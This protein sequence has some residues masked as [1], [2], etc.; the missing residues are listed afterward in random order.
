M[1]NK[2]TF[3]RTIAEITD[4]P[5]SDT[6]DAFKH[7]FQTVAKFILADDKPNLNKQGIEVEDFD[8]VA[9]S[10]VYM[11]V[12]MNFSKRG[13]LKNHIG[14]IP[15]GLITSTDKVISED[16]TN[17]LM[18]NAVLWTD[19]YPEEIA[20]LKESHASGDPEKLP[21]ISYEMAYADSVSKNGTQWL[22]KL[23]TLAA[24]FVKTPA[25]GSRTALLALASA[26]EMTLTDLAK[27]LMVLAKVEDQTFEKGG[28]IVDEKEMKALQ[29]RLAQVE[30]DLELARTE[31]STKAETIVSLQAQLN[32]KDEKITVLSSEKDALVKTQLIDARV[33][34]LA[35]HGIVLEADAEKAAKKKEFW[36]SLSDADFDEYVSDLQAA[37]KSSNKISLASVNPTISAQPLPKPT[38]LDAVNPKNLLDAMRNLGR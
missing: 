20:F 16:G 12:K 37:K 38:N 17:Q 23:I 8:E 18:A 35:E 5:S 32:E 26:G 14:S 9:R 3:E 22:K 4:I 15:I 34:K 2:A 7:P 31:A 6:T 10:A 33:R 30:K 25:Y 19:E 27:E 11:P 28:N 21:R 29:E 1:T 36:A 24:T 13:G